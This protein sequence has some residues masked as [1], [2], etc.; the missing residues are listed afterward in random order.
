MEGSLDPFWAV[1]AAAAAPAAA[2]T[3][4][5]LSKFWN[6]V[7]RKKSL[8]SALIA[9]IR[10]LGAAS[11][12]HRETFRS[13]KGQMQKDE[14]FVPFIFLSAAK[15]PAFNEVLT[16]WPE[17]AG[18]AMVA[19]TEFYNME[20]TSLDF[21]EN[22]RSKDWRKLEYSRRVRS[23]DLLDALMVDHANKAD[24]ALR[25]LGAKTLD[26]PTPNRPKRQEELA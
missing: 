7:R 8:R 26:R 1:L 15:T 9:E 22:L 11:I 14:D 18:D 19:V 17:V 3:F 10:V 25:S 24:A 16:E 2:F 23:F 20:T 12:S 6:G 13:L 21:I 5:S 4:E